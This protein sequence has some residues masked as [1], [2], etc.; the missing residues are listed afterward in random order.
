[1]L[2]LGKVNNL[3]D[4]NDENKIFSIT[5]VFTEIKSVLR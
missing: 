3:I 5:S 1:M 4:N 2:S